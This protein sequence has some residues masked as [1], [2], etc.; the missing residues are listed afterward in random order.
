M[1]AA[2]VGYG[3]NGTVPGTIVSGS[4]EQHP[5]IFRPYERGTLL[6]LCRTAGQQT[7]MIMTVRVSAQGQRFDHAR[8]VYGWGDQA[9]A[10]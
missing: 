2:V 8:S 9:R 7:A 10:L 3:A 5:S 1:L 6:V 4:V